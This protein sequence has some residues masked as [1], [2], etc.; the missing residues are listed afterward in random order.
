MSGY[1][2]YMLEY[3]SH[4]PRP[5]TQRKKLVPAKVLFSWDWWAIRH[6]PIELLRSNA[7]RAVN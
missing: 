1:N 6:R 7:L 3:K 2:I 4:Q 5:S